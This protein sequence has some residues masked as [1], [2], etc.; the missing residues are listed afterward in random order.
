MKKTN[1][2]GVIPIC[3]AS[4]TD[5]AEEIF[6]GKKREKTRLKLFEKSKIPRTADTLM[7]KPTSNRLSGFD[8][9]YP[10]TDAGYDKIEPI[11]FGDSV[12]YVYDS[13]TAKMLMLGYGVKPQSV[14]TDVINEC[15][16][17]RAYV[18]NESFTERIYIINYNNKYINSTPLYCEVLSEETM[19]FS[20]ETGEI[21]IL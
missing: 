14:P 20:T 18:F 15:A 5:S 8:K 4:E 17:V 2:T 6:F 11:F 19:C 9:F 10:L 7:R 16:I 1:E 12:G 3:A 21:F 13:G